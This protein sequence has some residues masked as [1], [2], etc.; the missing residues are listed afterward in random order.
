MNFGSASLHT[1]PLSTSGYNVIHMAKK[2]ATPE[3]P[4]AGLLGDWLTRALG[5]ES[6]TRIL[7]LLAQVPGKEFTGRELARVAGLAHRSV[8]LAMEDLVALDLVTR[9]RFGR[10][11]VYT[12]NREAHR[13][14]MVETLFREERGTLT[15]IQEASATALPDVD[16]A[17]LSG[18]VAR[19]QEGVESDLD[20]LIVSRHPEALRGSLRELESAIAGRFS[21]RPPPKG[22]TP[23]ELRRQ[24]DAPYLRAA[25]EQGI[26]VRG[27]ALEELHAGAA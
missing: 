3:R 1:V 16:S 2:V 5:T 11:N 20:L 12:A 21:I 26:L 24:W 27:R 4:P 10:A 7:R 8:D 6:R 22:L 23:R 9:R 19:G 25:R 17:V 15:R 13:F 14:R 18:S